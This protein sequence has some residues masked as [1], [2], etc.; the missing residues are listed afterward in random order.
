MGE[1]HWA[2]WVAA[3]LAAVMGTFAHMRVRRLPAS[4]L[5]DYLSDLSWL[6]APVLAL[7]AWL[8]VDPVTALL[9]ASILAPIVALRGVVFARTSGSPPNNPDALPEDIKTE[10]D[11]LRA[12]LLGRENASTD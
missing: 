5:R 3:G 8:G 2:T 12:R 10:R 11:A 9:G 7:Q 4:H 1:H 6:P